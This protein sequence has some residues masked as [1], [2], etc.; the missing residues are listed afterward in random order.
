VLARKF[1]VILDANP[2]ALVA[3]SSLLAEVVRCLAGRVT[4][5]GRTGFSVVADS[6]MP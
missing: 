2:D 4:K 3:E 6:D 5:R 1:A